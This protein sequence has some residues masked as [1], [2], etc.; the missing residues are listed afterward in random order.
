MYL[1]P[2]HQYQASNSADA[3]PYMIHQ[4]INRVNSI[5]L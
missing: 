5:S 2:F 1:V 4:V 3:R